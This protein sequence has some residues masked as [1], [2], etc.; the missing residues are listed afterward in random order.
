MTRNP[1]TVSFRILT[2]NTHKGFTPLNRRFILHELR[3][4]VHAVSADALVVVV[5]PVDVAVVSTGAGATALAAAAAAPN[6]K[7]SSWMLAFRLRP[8]PD[9]VRPTDWTANSR[10]DTSSAPLCTAT[11]LRRR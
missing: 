3:D 1:T 7:A 6:V 2:V 10:P 4:A 5:S 8:V 9:G 11:R